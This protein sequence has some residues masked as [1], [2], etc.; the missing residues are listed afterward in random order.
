MK[1]TE[2]MEGAEPKLPGAPKGIQIMTTQQ[3]VT[4]S[5]GEEEKLDELSPETL[6]GYKKK[7]GLEASK[8]DKQAFGN[9]VLAK[10]KIEKA[11]KRFS[12]IVRATNKELSKSQKGVAEGAPEL[13]KKEIQEHEERATF[14]EK[15]FEKA[16]GLMN[17]PQQLDENDK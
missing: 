16:N 13:L 12:G 1:Y 4:K 7:A 3:F 8:L 9:D 17:Y 5:A 2:L 14:T 6:A 15:E 10:Q 11:N